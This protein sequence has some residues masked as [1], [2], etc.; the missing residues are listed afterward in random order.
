[1]FIKH[2]FSF[3]MPSKLTFKGVFLNELG[4]WGDK[5]DFEKGLQNYHRFELNGNNE[6][7]D[8]E[9]NIMDKLYNEGGKEVFYK[10]YICN[11]K[12]EIIRECKD[13]YKYDSTGRPLNQ[14]GELIKLN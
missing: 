6:L 5:Y 12:G 14:K 8:F 10:D 4:K 11:N 7:I 13:F 2:V 1:M 3:K 9:D